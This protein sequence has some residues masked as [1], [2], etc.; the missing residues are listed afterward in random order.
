MLG[1]NRVWLA[2]EYKG[3]D[4]DTM[5]INLRDKPQ[6]F[7]ELIP[8]GLV[9]VAKVKDKLVHESYDILKVCYATVHQNRFCHFQSLPAKSCGGERS[10]K[11]TPISLESSKSVRLNRGF[12]AVMSL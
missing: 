3:I 5:F 1:W 9:P 10:L 6:W 11:M 2:L 12:I 8:T 7:L 4:Y